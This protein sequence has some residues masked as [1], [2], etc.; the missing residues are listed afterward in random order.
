MPTRP[1]FTNV[2]LH[3]D[4]ELAEL[5]GGRIDERETIHAWPLSCVQAVRMADGTRLVYKVQLP[6]T[7]EPEFYASASSSLLP[8]CR[9]LGPVGQ[10]VALAI[11][12][13]DAPTLSQVV[14]GG[15]VLGRGRDIV[16]EIAGI[17]GDLPSYLDIGSVATWA[18]VV[19][20]VLSRR[21]DLVAAG[22]F[23]HRDRDA[24]SRLRTWAESPAVL[25]AIGARSRVI[26]GDLTGNQVFVTDSG[27]RV[28]DWQRPVIAPAEADLVS[29]LVDQHVE[30]RGVVDDAV[31]GVFWFLRLHWAVVAQDELFP[32]AP[33]KLFNDWARESVDKILQL[34]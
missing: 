17:G 12:W 25:S 20:E 16:S 27:Y 31:V 1:V 4:G 30:P 18:A 21:E 7:V 26:H 2:V 8:G 14:R 5:L 28:I 6:P 22:W 29:L 33:R 24:A 3:S 11:D 15:G 9:P 23:T 10:G 32:D 19:D 13:I 34:C